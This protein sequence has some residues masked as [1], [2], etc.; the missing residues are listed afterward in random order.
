MITVYA[1]SKILLNKIENVKFDRGKIFRLEHRERTKV[2]DQLSLANVDIDIT[3]LTIIFKKLWS[4]Q[5]SKTHLLMHSAILTE[6]EQHLLIDFLNKIS[7]IKFNTGDSELIARAIIDLKRRVDNNQFTDITNEDIHLLYRYL[8]L[9]SMLQYNLAPSFYT[10]INVDPLDFDFVKQTNEL[11]CLP[12]T[13]RNR[14]TV[15]T[16]SSID[17]RKGTFDFGA[18]QMKLT[19]VLRHTIL[20]SVLFPSINQDSS[21]SESHEY[22]DLIWT[23]D[24]NAQNFQQWEEYIKELPF[25]SFAQESEKETKL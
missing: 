25:D 19:R 20:T 3:R 13:F 15:D 24:L 5:S 4:S 17:H 10:S 22:V 1:N 7:K 9:N 12:I 18:F 23:D 8:Y 2:K 14:V 11:I 6:E 16:V 21:K